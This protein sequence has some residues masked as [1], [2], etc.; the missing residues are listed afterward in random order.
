MPGARTPH[1][2]ALLASR[3]ARVSVDW[4][5]HRFVQALSPEAASR[6]IRGRPMLRRLLG[7]GAWRVGDSV[8]RMGGALLVSAYVARYLHPTGFGLLSFAAAMATLVTAIAQFGM[9]TV[10]V[11]GTGPSSAGASRDPGDALVLRLVAGAVS[12]V[13]AMGATVV[14]RPGDHGG[15]RRRPHRLR[16]R[17]A[18][19]VGRHRLRLSGAHRKRAR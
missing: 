19:S 15:S 1:A 13:L 8:F 5:S 7:N 6:F 11:E 10:A 18:T 9:Q 4:R 2:I 3:D 17:I 16:D 14:M 12:I